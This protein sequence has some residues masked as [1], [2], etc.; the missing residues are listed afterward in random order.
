MY[1]MQSLYFDWFQQFFK[2]Y[3]ISVLCLDA[4]VAIVHRSVP[5]IYFFHLKK[6]VLLEK[7]I[8]FVNRFTW[9]IS[10]YCVVYSKHFEEKF[11]FFGKRTKLKCALNLIP[12][13]HSCCLETSFN[14]TYTA[15]KD[16][17][18]SITGNDIPVIEKFC[19]LVQKQCSTSYLFHKTKNHIIYY[20]PCFDKKK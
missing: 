9:L 12:S 20:K 17:L 3:L 1:N 2:R 19:N 18:E 5:R 6:K 11:L 8:R 13:I 16:Q 15:R 4:H 7:W 14:F 10:K